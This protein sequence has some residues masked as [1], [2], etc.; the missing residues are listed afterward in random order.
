[1]ARQLL[2]II[3]LFLVMACSQESG[4]EETTTLPPGVGFFTAFDGVRIAFTDEGEG[5]P[6]ILIHG[7]INSGANWDRTELKQQLLTAGYRV[8]V[9]DLRGN[10]YSDKPQTDSAYA[11]DAE[12]K[13]LLGLAD[14]LA[15][16]SYQAIGYS[17]GSIVLA[18]LLTQDDR[19]TS[20][21]LGGMG[22]D[23][24]DPDWPRRKLFAAAFA[25]NITEETQGAVA[26]A[27]SIQADL[28]SLALQQ[29]YQPVT[30]P[31]EL[32]EVEIPVLVI[33][34]NEDKD[35][36]D[37][38]ALERQFPAGKLA[39]VPGDHNNTYRGKVFAAAVMAFIKSTSTQ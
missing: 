2:S 3:L 4:R 8:I 34:G 22:L 24:T 38:G 9:P 25:G 37:P 33:A 13:D 20:A 35:N 23:F 7:F 21:V 16:P 14:H 28:R 12:V 10:G 32:R 39:I 19:I 1:M 31:E 11:K 6:V 26:Y 17:R 29:Q 5:Q 18:K 36:G 27:K 15:L 30:L